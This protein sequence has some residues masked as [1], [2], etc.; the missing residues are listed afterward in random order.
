[1]TG[2]LNPSVGSN[3]LLNALPDQVRQAM[4]ADFDTARFYKAQ[5]LAESGQVL[6]HVYFPTTCLLSLAVHMEGGARV[7]ISMM[8]MRGFVGISA[9]L[10]S[11]I[12]QHT[13]LC[14]IEGEAFR[15][16]L[17]AFTRHLRNEA[18]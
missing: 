6:K 16:D 18:L 11:P 10:G 2:P 15:M 5:V 3:L 7:E 1:M 13:V 12:S 14:E 17:E 4:S 9:L 8:G